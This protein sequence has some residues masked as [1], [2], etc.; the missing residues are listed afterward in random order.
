MRRS[1]QQHE[2]GARPDG[3]PADVVAEQGAGT[4]VRRGVHRL[5]RGHPHLADRQR[6]AQR[7]RAGEARARVA[8]AGQRHRD[9]GVEQPPRVRVGLP[10]RELHPGQQRGDRPRVAERVDVRVGQVGAVVDR[11]QPEL[12]GEQHAGARAELAGVQP[13]LQAVRRPGPEH[14]AGL[15]DV[16]GTLLAEGVDP[17]RVR[18]RGL[19]HRAGHQLDVAGRVIG[20]LGRD[21]VRAE[22]RGLVGELPRHCQAARLVVDGQPVAGLDLDGGGAL[23]AHLLRPAGRRGR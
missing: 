3:E 17:A 18:R 6:D 23:P 21:D 8:V 12:G 20:V 15:V 4:A 11:G 1:V 16:E 7:H 13:A 10:R 9:A 14:R 22:E 5:G 19:E 2:V